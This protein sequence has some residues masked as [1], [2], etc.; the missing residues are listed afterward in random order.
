M[1]WVNIVIALVMMVVGE[2]LRPKV[3]PDKA[4]P[5]AIGEFNFPTVDATRVVPYFLG[6]CKLEGPNVPWFGDLAVVE[7]KKKVK[8]GWFSSAQ[9]HVAWHYYL[10]VQFIFGFGELDEFIELRADD[11]V[12]NVSTTA[13]TGSVCSFQ[14]NSP[15]I[16]DKEDPVS[17][18]VGP[19]R[20]YKGTFDQPPNLY[21]GQQWD[22]DPV[23]AFRPL[24]MLVLEHVY[25]G[26]TET[27]PPISLIGRRTPNGLGLTGGKHN[28]NGDANIACGCFEIMTNS[29]FG[30]NID[31]SK[32]DTDSFVYWGNYTAEEGLGISMQ[33]QTSMEGKDLLA[34]ILRHA[35]G[36][37]Y[38]DP[39][40]GLYT[41]SL[42]RDDYLE[43]IDDLLILDNSSIVPDTFEFSRVSWEQTKNNIIVNF[44]DRATFQSTP[45]QYQDLANIDVRRG[46]IDTESIDFLGFSNAGAAMNAAQR[47]C[48]IKASP[49]MRAQFSLNRIGW[50]LRP[51][52]VVKLQK[53]DKGIAQLIMRII[54]IDYGTLDDMTIKV[55]AME[56]VFAIGFSAYTEPAES[57]WGGLAQPPLPLERQAL[58]E[59]PYEFIGSTQS[60]V[61]TLASKREANTFAYDIYTSPTTNV[62]GNYV[63]RNR[64]TEFTPSG[65]MELGCAGT[66]GPYQLDAA[67]FVLIDMKQAGEVKT[68]SVGDQLAGDSIIYVKSING[69][70]FMGFRTVTD[71]GSGRVS[72]TDIYRGLFG[73]LVAPHPAGTVVWF[74]HAGF[75]IIEMPSYDAFPATMWARLCPANFKAVL[76]LAS[77]TGM[78][79]TLTNRA[80]AAYPIIRPKINGVAAPVVSTVG[81]ALLTWEF[82]NPEARGAR[83]NS[84][85]PDGDPV[86]PG[87]TF[88]VKV[89]VGGV[90]KRT[91]TGL[92]ATNYNYT[93]AMRLADSTNTAQTVQFRVTVVRGARSSAEVV[94]DPFLM[95]SAAVAVTITNATPL[96]AAIVGRGYSVTLA[97]TGGAGAPYVF[98][99]VGGSLPPGMYVANGVL[100]GVC[101]TAGTYSFTLQAASGTSG[102][103]AFTLTVA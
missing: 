36:V 40:T 45:V 4:Q 51:G 71:L 50:Q 102:T 73:T 54:E 42:A 15:D 53:P 59:L 22:E 84:P 95:T 100:S 25:L 7:I 46:F 33:I 20:L 30:M 41:L 43:Y 91:V 75:G 2:L 63:P 31:E 18:V 57:D 96:P 89:Y 32:I 35:D 44:T 67:G 39:L 55:V 28:V 82:I 58:V 85:F 93:V 12:L 86:T 61:A 10:G 60:M 78:Q 8:T 56:D 19:A 81:D 99:H 70:E 38:I 52:S 77:A 49:L 48:R 11:K 9:M 65:T 79:I 101:P 69:E 72:F 3:K 47:A 64:T 24:I 23:S 37:I 80:A 97:A 83:I 6:T 90:L 66:V 103:K 34:E 27:P 76:P 21:L 62:V 74:M 92:T 14:I 16:L 26:N 29:L 1:I 88:T 5:S 94:L 17:G 98:S 68:V 13:F 87:T